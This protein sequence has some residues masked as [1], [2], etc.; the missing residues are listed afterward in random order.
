MDWFQELHQSLISGAKRLIW[1]GMMLLSIQL[2]LC[3]DNQCNLHLWPR[4]KHRRLPCSFWIKSL[5][6][7]YLGLEE[8]LLNMRVKSNN[9]KQ[10][11]TIKKFRVRLNDFL[12]MMLKRL[13]LSI[14]WIW[15]WLTLISV[16]IKVD[17]STLKAI[18][19]RAK[20]W[21]TTTFIKRASIMM[22]VNSIEEIKAIEIMLKATMTKKNSRE[23]RIGFNIRIKDRPLI[24]R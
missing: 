6:I 15:L 22:R 16:M 1:I 8:G 20:W 23:R 12:E 5:M 19:L 3:L 14:Q 9:K 2:I 10:R 4:V 13:M 21:V 24:N 17:L 18:S 7:W 11:E